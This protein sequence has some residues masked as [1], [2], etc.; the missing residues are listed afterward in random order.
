MNLSGQYHGYTNFLNPIQTN[1]I[2]SWVS[3]NTT[4]QNNLEGMVQLPPPGIGL[5]QHCPSAPEPLPRRRRNWREAGAQDHPEMSWSFLAVGKPGLLNYTSMT[6]SSTNNLMNE[7]KKRTC[8]A[9]NLDP[10]SQ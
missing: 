8:E 6:L 1:P 10:N 5:I 2:H 9:L 4:C 3:Y 7:I